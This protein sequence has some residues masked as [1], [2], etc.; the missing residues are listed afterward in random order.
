MAMVPIVFSGMATSRRPARCLLRL[1]QIKRRKYG[2][3]CWLRPR[4]IS[5]KCRAL[6]S[7]L[8][9]AS[10]GDRT[11]PKH[12][13]IQQR[14]KR[15]SGFFI[16]R[17]ALAIPLPRTAAA[18]GSE[19]TTLKWK[20]IATL[21]KLLDCDVA[22]LCPGLEVMG[23]QCDEARLLPRTLVVVHKLPVQRHANLRAVGFNF[24]FVP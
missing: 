16:W 6:H 5:S 9:E 15:N 2:Y 17:A 24:I 12:V 22:K 13:I 10:R 14:D 23:L 18:C 20:A 7:S 1:R 11:S 4:A 19:G 8:T 3:L 21:G